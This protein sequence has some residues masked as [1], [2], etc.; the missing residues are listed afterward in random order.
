MNL[1]LGVTED[2]NCVATLSGIIGVLVTEGVLVMV[3]VGV[4]VDVSVIVGVVVM[5]GVNVTVGEGGNTR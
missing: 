4:M 3:A 2:R 5:V 1:G